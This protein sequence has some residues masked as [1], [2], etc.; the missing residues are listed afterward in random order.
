MANPTNRTPNANATPTPTPVY[1]LTPEGL[2][3][4]IDAI[5]APARNPEDRET[6]PNPYEAPRP[7]E[8]N[9]NRKTRFGLASRFETARENATK[10]LKVGTAGFSGRGVSIYDGLRAFVAS[11]P[12]P[13]APLT[14]KN[15]AGL[16][17][18]SYVLA[19]PGRSVS[20]TGSTVYSAYT[21]DVYRLAGLVTLD[22]KAGGYTLAPAFRARLAGEPSKS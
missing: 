16:A 15:L 3:S 22:A 18:K 6:N 21:L 17:E 9:A 10:A 4:A 19:N 5:L 20:K 1:P 14:L 12:N 7:G 11:N 8:T 13:S 2:A